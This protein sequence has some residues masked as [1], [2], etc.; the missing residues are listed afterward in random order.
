MDNYNYFQ[1]KVLELIN[2]N[3]IIFS[4]TDDD[5]NLINSKIKQFSE[6]DNP[7]APSSIA[8]SLIYNI[9]RQR[10]PQ[11]TIKMIANKFKTDIITSRYNRSTGIKIKTNK[12]ISVFSIAKWRT[13]IYNLL[14]GE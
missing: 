7:C 12:N 11:L 9:L 1:H 6:I 3:S 5:I 2:R 8:A 10:N 14:Y 4:L 13:K